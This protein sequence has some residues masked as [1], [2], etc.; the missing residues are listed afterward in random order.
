MQY[1]IKP[2]LHQRQVSDYTYSDHL[3]FKVE[4]RWL[5]LW[6]QVGGGYFKTREEAQAV[7]DH[8]TNKEGV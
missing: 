7:I 1:R 8:L 6:L 4:K 3:Y 5:W 2:I